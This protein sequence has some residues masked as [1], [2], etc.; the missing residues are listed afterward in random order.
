MNEEMMQ[1]EVGAIVAEIAAPAQE[2]ATAVADPRLEDLDRRIRDLEAAI[3]D[4]RTVSASA[5]TSPVA[6]GRKTQPSY[7]PHLLAKGAEPVR[8]AAVDDA[9]SSLSVEQRFAVKAGLLRA[10][11]L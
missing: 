9:L 7:A 4:L 6:S 2:A 8:P 1:H 5:A 11:I 10:G 3:A